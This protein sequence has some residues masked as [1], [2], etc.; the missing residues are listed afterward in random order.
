[1][2]QYAAVNVNKSKYSS[3]EATSPARGCLFLEPS[4][5]VIKIK[6]V[7]LSRD[8]KRVCKAAL[9]RIICC[10]LLLLGKSIPRDALQ[11]CDSTVAGTVYEIGM[12]RPSQ[13]NQ[14]KSYAEH[15]Q[16]CDFC[17]DICR[18]GFV[19]LQKQH[20]PQSTCSN[21]CSAVPS[22]F[23]PLMCCGIFYP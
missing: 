16:A 9:K 19:H 13:P 7:L 1:M 10:S 8:Q 15:M 17:R 21:T 22:I 12:H 5:S 14:A 23:I 6:A 2:S 11:V 20:F 18:E 3:H 4:V